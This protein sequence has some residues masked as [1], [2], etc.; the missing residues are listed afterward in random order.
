M[1]GQ[2]ER[3]QRHR[4]AVKKWRARNSDKY[5]ESQRVAKAR[6]RAQK[7]DDPVYQERIREYRRRI[8]NAQRQAMEVAQMQ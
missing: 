4:V 1:L 8:Y 6:W 7:K 5:R 2:E 3:K